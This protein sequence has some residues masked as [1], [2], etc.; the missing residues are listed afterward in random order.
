MSTQRWLDYWIRSIGEEILQTRKKYYE[1]SL[2]HG[3]AG[4]YQPDQWHS[5]HT[6]MCSLYLFNFPTSTSI[7][8]CRGQILQP[9]VVGQSEIW[10]GAWD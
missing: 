4:D 6:Y 3:Y 2:F 9:V 10:E 5:S 1:T 7:L 8:R